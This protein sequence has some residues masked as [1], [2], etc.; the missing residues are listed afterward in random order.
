MAVGDL[1]VINGKFDAG[2]ADIFMINENS[3]PA[4]VSGGTFS[5]EIPEEY[6]EE[7]FHP[8]KNPDGS[9]SVHVHQSGEAV[10]ENEVDSSCTVKG[11]YDSVVYC[12][13][14]KE[15]LSRETIDIDV[16]DHSFGEWG[17]SNLT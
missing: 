7:N 5:N 8:I 15:E 14:C 12:T 6:C 11:H 2:T 3:A 1:S 16:K 17:D 10:R 9:Y 13:L 4:K